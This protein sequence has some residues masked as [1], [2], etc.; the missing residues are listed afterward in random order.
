MTE[1][2]YQL[3]ITHYQLLITNYQLPIT[4]YPLPI[5]KLFFFNGG[6]CLMD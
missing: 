2:N 6:F 1:I 5:G 4:H 3:P